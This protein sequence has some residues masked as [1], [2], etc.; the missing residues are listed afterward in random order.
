MWSKNLSLPT[1]L[2]ALPCNRLQDG[3][4]PF[5]S[6]DT[7]LS[8]GSQI[9]LRLLSSFT[10]RPAENPFCFSPVPQLTSLPWPFHH[11]HR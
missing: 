6:I 11:P 4:P 1:V 9:S 10:H 2:R 5:P 8:R 3:Q 7:E